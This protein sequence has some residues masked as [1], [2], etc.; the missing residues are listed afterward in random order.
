MIYLS[1]TNIIKSNTIENLILNALERYVDEDVFTDLKETNERGDYL[2]D[3]VQLATKY[4]MS[5]GYLTLI[6][7]LIKLWLTVDKEKT[8]EAI[9]LLL[10]QDV[11]HTLRDA[12]MYSDDMFAVWEDDKNEYWIIPSQSLK[13][14]VFEWAQ[15]AA[16][17]DVDAIRFTAQ[18][19]IIA[20]MYAEWNNVSIFEKLK[21]FYHKHFKNGN[22]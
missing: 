12:R 4:N 16:S 10:L 15:R 8:V 7:A 6:H 17:W 22:R 14:R 21:R 11:I 19:A 3:I 5:W 18:A 1:I 9:Q 20:F 2:L 13:I